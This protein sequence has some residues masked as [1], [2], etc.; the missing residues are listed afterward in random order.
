MPQHQQAAQNQARAAQ[1][2]TNNPMLPLSI[3]IGLP[4][5]TM[6]VQFDRKHLD[7]DVEACYVYAECAKSIKAE[8]K[9]KVHAERNC[10]QKGSLFD[11]G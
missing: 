5:S 7:A 11:F 3:A 1:L 4:R 2:G 10:G 8:R 9:S 6:I